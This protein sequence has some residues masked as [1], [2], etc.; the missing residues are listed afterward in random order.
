MRDG[1]LTPVDYTPFFHL[2]ETEED[3]VEH[4]EE[5]SSSSCIVETGSA[6]KSRNNDLF[7]MQRTSLDWVAAKFGNQQDP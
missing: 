7:A 1:A 3:N 6:K 5:A 2:L 4:Q